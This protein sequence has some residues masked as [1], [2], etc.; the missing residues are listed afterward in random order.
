MRTEGKHRPVRS[1]N[2]TRFC[3]VQ[4]RCRRTV[5]YRS[6]VTGMKGSKAVSWGAAAPCS[7]AVARAHEPYGKNWLA[8]FGEFAEDRCRQNTSILP[9]LA[10]YGSPASEPGFAISRFGA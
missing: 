4:C 1:A 5:R 9:A 7:K 2:A 8:K 3:S 6:R 10:G